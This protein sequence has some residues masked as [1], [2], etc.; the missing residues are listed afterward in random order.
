MILYNITFNIELA[1]EQD[2]LQWVKTNY[3]P[4]IEA[5]NLATDC[6]ILK[7]LTEIDNGG[8]TYALQCWFVSM[9]TCTLF[10]DKHADTI[11]YEHY[12]QFKGCFV[13]FSTLL[14]EIA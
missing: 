9:E 10:Q 5:T 12:Q 11:Q 2:W 1:I 7:L 3:V 14:E 13:E 6:R 4:S 8:A